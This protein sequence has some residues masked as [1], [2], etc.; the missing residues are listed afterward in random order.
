MCSRVSKRRKSAQPIS[1]PEP[2]AFPIMISAWRICSRRLTVLWAVLLAGLVPG[3]TVTGKVELRDSKDPSVRKK[4][5]FS[6]IVVWLEST[7]AK[8]PAPEP[9]VHARMTQKDKTF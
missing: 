1:A 6:G 5:N 3:A 7:G 2:G 4:M 9:A 8:K